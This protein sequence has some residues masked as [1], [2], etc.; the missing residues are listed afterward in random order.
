MSLRSLRS[1]FAV[2]PGR[3]RPKVLR[4]GALLFGLLL[5]VLYAS[6]SRSIPL[7]PKGGEVLK[8][9]FRDAANVR[10]GTAVRI[11]GVDVGTVDSVGSSGEGAGRL[12]V[13]KMRVDEGDAE[14]LRRDAG[15]TVYWRTLLGR[16]MYIELDPGNA[17]EPLGG[18]TI[19][20]DRTAAQVEL[21][22]ALEPLDDGGRKSLQG[23]FGFLDEGF[24]EPK[25]AQETI[26]RLDPAMR[27]LAPAAR[28]LRGQGTGDLIAAVR[29]TRDVAR[30]LDGS[31]AQLGNLI[32]AGAVTLGVTAA[33]R[34]DLAST[35]QI[36]PGSL[37]TT[38]AEMVK[39]RGTLDRLDPLVAD[40]GP[41]SRR[42]ARTSK[43]L[44]PALDD[45]RPVLRDAKPLLRDLQ[46]AV[47]RLRRTA[48]Q[49]VPLIREL[50]P[51]V[52]RLKKDTIPFLNSKDDSGRKVHQLV[53][54][55]LSALD[56][57]AQNFDLNGHD[58]A[59]QAGGGARLVEGFVPCSAYLTD[60]TT[61][62]KVRCDGFL[63]GLNQLFGPPKPS[64]TSSGGTSPVSSA[65]GR[66]VEVSD[67]VQEEPGDRSADAGAAAP[68]RASSALGG[69]WDDARRALETKE[70]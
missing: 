9:E 12:A 26:D 38:R 58:I 45:L 68:K 27:E 16:N 35:L 67:R 7:L 20:A 11:R 4:N 21:D 17:P 70:P 13:V 2:A 41:G 30:A 25:P 49:G 22:K 15:A 37:A 44:R 64:G 69:Y 32:D 54:P 47:K 34:A 66:A 6:Y 57:A 48:R 46:P 29:G 3:H 18:G 60:P 19:T 59:F 24:K 36:A 53:G 10:K 52:D 55:T 31:E 62:E 56:S 33:R 42:L 39:L 43:V 40:L 51:T 5:V 63:A 61:T 23:F 1:R 28:A 8:A 14:V 50:T 65:A